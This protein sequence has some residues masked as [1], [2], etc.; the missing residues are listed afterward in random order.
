MGRDQDTTIENARA[1]IKSDI[2]I[3]RDTHHC[4]PSL[5]A[6][7]ESLRTY[8]VAA[9]GNHGG[10]LFLRAGCLPPPAALDKDHPRMR[11]LA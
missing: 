3:Q 6:A 9:A 8:L 7:A 5:K 2:E 10:Y 11:V 4:G 1:S